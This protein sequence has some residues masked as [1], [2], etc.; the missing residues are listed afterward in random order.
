ML[1]TFPRQHRLIFDMDGM[2]NPVIKLD[3]YDFNHRDEASRAQWIEFYDTLADR[4]VKPTLAPPGQSPGHRPAVLRLRPRVAGR[5]GQGP[6]Q[7]VRHPPRRPQLV[8]VE[9]G[10]R[11]VAACVRAD[12][13]PGRRDRLHRPVV[14]PASDRGPGSGPAEAFRSD[15]E[16]F[17]RLRIR[18]DGCRDVY[19]RDP[20]DELRARSTFS[21]S[22][23]CC[24]T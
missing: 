22:A 8:A 11:R 24:I 14:G 15:P 6:A 16:A 23:P 4:V 5:S 9:G 10:G 3:G 21:R 20:D 2:Y 18:T 13:R 12:P 17:R 7:A 19:R 1:G